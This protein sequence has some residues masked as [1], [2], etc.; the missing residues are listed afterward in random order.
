MS[1]VLLVY[2]TKYGATK[3]IAERIAET[4]QAAGHE[5]RLVPAENAPAVDG[6]DAVVVGSAVYIGKMRKAMRQ[7]L[8]KNQEILSQ[9]PVW[10][11]ASGPTGKDDQPGE[12]E[13]MHRPQA[14]RDLIDKIGPKERVVL[15]GALLRDALSG[16]D[17]WMISQA[18]APLDDARDWD[19]I[20]GWAQKIADELSAG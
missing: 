5:T 6:F 3:E 8:K 12:F 18:K 9:K 20:A 19:A 16:L 11:F 14:I 1:K 17:R 13:G 4:I 2:A 7:F 10:L 15:G